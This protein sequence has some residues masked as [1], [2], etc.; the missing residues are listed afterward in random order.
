[1]CNTRR[2][3]FN[4]TFHIA[5]PQR[6]DGCAN[7]IITLFHLIKCMIIPQREIRG[8]DTTGRKKRWQQCHWAAK[9]AAGLC[10]LRDT[11]NMVDVTM[12]L[13]QQ[14][15]PLFFCI[16]ISFFNCYYGI[17]KSVKEII[18]EAIFLI[19]MKHFVITVCKKCFTNKAYLLT[20][21]L[22]IKNIPKRSALSE[23]KYLKFG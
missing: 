14:F 1:M 16:L 13:Q 5:M 9:H 3:A 23:C 2:Y 17:C 10:P 18:L 20:Y 12:S 6:K 21:L 19:S 7:F 22:T 8:Q 15:P 11:V 4:K